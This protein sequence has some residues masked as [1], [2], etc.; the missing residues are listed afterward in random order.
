MERKDFKN[1]LISAL[2]EL[3]TTNYENIK[4]KIKPVLEVGK[5]YNSDDDFMKLAV[6]DRANLEINILV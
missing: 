2:L 5:R 1:N 4:F 6:L 3:K